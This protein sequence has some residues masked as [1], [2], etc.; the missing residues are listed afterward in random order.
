MEIPTWTY[1]AVCHNESVELL[2]IAVQLRTH[3]QPCDVMLNPKHLSLTTFYLCSQ[4]DSSHEVRLFTR[5]LLFR[6]NMRMSLPKGAS[7]YFFNS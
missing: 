4:I 1:A 3:K 7:S 2:S 5:V 6:F